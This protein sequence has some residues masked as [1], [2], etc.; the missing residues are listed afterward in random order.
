MSK[1][2]EI[3]AIVKA[4]GIALV[5]SHPNIV[6]V[7]Y[8]FKQVGEVT[9]DEECIRHFEFYY[10][11]KTPSTALTLASELSFMAAY[12]LDEVKA[13]V[14]RHNVL[15]CSSNDKRDAFDMFVVN[16]PHTP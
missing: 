6:S 2:D 7:S 8:S 1:Q 13:S 9:T 4:I 10:R 3:K 12:T 5:E 15:Q 11:F 14:A 16:T